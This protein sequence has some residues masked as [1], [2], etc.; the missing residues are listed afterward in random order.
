MPNTISRAEHIGIGELSKRT[1]VHIETI[2]YYERSGVM[3]K[4]PRS[5]RG[6]RTY[7]ETFVRRLAFVSRSRQLGFS[8]DEIRSLLG[9]VDEH[10]YT[11]ADVRE[12]T[13]KHA[14]EARRKIADLR[15][16][17]RTLKDMAAQCHGD[18]VPDCPIVDNLFDGK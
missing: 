13:L 4:P 2:R 10:E 3:P 9:L 18:R 1:G 16:L 5:E 6:Q 7:D 17:E 8:L 12:L 11:C 14:A 15:K